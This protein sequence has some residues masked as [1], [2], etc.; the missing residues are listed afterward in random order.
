MPHFFAFLAGDAAVLL[1]LP[2]FFAFTVLGLAVLS[3][4]GD[5]F[6]TGT[7]FGAVFLT[8]A[9]FLT[10]AVFSSSFLVAAGTL[11]LKAAFG[12]IAGF[13][14]RDFGAFT[15]LAAAVV[16]FTRPAGFLTTLVGLGALVCS[17]SFTSLINATGLVA[18]V[19]FLSS[20][21]SLKEFFTLKTFPCFVKFRSWMDKV[22]LKFGGKPVLY[23]SSRYL[24]IAYWLD[25]VLSF[26]LPIASFTIWSKQPQHEP[27]PT[28]Y[29]HSWVAYHGY[30][31][32]CSMHLAKLKQH[33]R[34]QRSTTSNKIGMYGESPAHLL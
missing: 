15:G 12:A 29:A 4:F 6:T 22:F 3:D 18:L 16:F 31:L 24:A 25:P 8:A 19:G 34:Q 27:S 23:V 20:S 7:F 1:A 9:G 17:P 13:F 2:G 10:G 11:L 32:A 21:E 28:S 26:K 5:F 30:H 33:E 14:L